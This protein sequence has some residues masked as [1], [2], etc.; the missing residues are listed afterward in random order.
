M[1]WHLSYSDSIVIL[2]TYKVYRGLT[3]ESM[4]TF[5]MDPTVRWLSLSQTHKLFSS[6]NWLL[7]SLL[8]HPKCDFWFLNYK[9]IWFLIFYRAENLFET[10]KTTYG[11]KNVFFLCINSQAAQSADTHLPDPWSQF[12]TRRLQSQVSTL[13]TTK[14]NSSSAYVAFI[15]AWLRTIFIFFLPSKPW[16]PNRFW[17]KL[18]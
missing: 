10:M 9:T 7:L 1:R 5:K 13:L 16:R 17:S 18:C 6:L 3:F 4:R 11:V 2:S 8:A 15:L 12:L 14:Q